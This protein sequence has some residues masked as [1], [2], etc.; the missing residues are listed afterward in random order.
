MKNEVETL[1]F[2]IEQQKAEIRFLRTTLKVIVSGV[3]DGLSQ[4]DMML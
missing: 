3:K 4:S 2:V 1:N